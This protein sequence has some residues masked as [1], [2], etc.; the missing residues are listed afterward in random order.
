MAVQKQNSVL[1]RPGVGGKT[2]NG[3]DMCPFFGWF[4]FLWH[5]VHPHVDIP[6]WN[7]NQIA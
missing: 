7:P 2:Q 5:G 4:E 6:G 3:P 1:Q